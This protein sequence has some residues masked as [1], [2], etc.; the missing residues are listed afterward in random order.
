MK[1]ILPA[2]Q[3]HLPKTP[4]CLTVVVRKCAVHALTIQYVTVALSHSCL[5]SCLGLLGWLGLGSLPACV[6]AC[7]PVCVHVLFLHNHQHHLHYHHLSVA[8]PI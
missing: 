8:P 6:P 5:L 1:L 4:I 3:Q 2:E 7:L